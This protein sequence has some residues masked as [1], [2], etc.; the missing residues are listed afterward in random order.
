MPEYRR[1]SVPGGTFFFT[2]VTERRAPI[3]RDAT[4]HTLLRSAFKKAQARWPFTIEAI[5]VLPD[6][7]HTIWSLPE[8]DADFSTRWSFVKRKFSQSWLAA[9]GGEQH[10]SE[11]RKRDRRLGV[12]QR[13]F[14]EHLIRDDG[15][16]ERH[17]DYIH[18]NPVKHGYVSCP[19]SWAHSSF[20]RFVGEGYYDESWQCACDS[21]QPVPLDF[22]DIDT[23]AVE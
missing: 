23:T 21:R 10:V 19:H 2:V 4:S 13:R 3:L 9:G 8:G 1:A 20:Q 14:W 15:D 6:H 18:Y 22:G 12:W 7:L 16:F 17:C 5:A 11:S